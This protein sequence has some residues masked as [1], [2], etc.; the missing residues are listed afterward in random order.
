MKCNA[1][2]IVQHL[3]DYCDIVGRRVDDA[4]QT[5]QGF[6]TAGE[7]GDQAEDRLI[8]RFKKANL[9]RTLRRSLAEGRMPSM[10]LEDK[11][12]ISIIF[13]NLRLSRRYGLDSMSDFPF[14]L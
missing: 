14:M 6:R 3:R 11:T 1:Q 4:I 5:L 10:A 7:C 8:R 2:Q 13:F 9:A 12:L